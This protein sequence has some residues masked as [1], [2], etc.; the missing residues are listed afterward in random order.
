MKNRSPSISKF[1]LTRRARA[2][3]FVIHPALYRRAA[4]RTYNFPNAVAYALYVYKWNVS[5]PTTSDAPNRSS[6]QSV[7]SIFHRART[8]GF[9]HHDPRDRA[10]LRALFRIREIAIE[11]YAK[12][13]NL[14]VLACRRN[15]HTHMRY[16]VPRA[17][18]TVCACV[19]IARGSATRRQAV[20]FAKI[21]HTP[22]E[23][24]ASRDVSLA[25][26]RR[27]IRPS[28]SSRSRDSS[29]VRC[30]PAAVERPCVCKSDATVR[31][32]ICGTERA[33]VRSRVRSVADARYRSVS[34]AAAESSLSG[35]LRANRFRVLAHARRAS[36]GYRSVAR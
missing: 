35:N 33:R 8:P 10:S 14:F 5:A 17:S 36:A 22:H 9:F 18:V 1:N 12:T 4:R 6:A 20:L 7:L 25:V 28:P 3:Y 26:V 16:I 32:D 27:K 21:A 2:V 31:P 23:R 24:H 30:F 11:I 34:R 13:R 15:T 29:P 19:C